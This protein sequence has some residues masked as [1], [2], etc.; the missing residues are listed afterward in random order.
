MNADLPSEG[1][2]PD[3]APDVG[4]TEAGAERP[5]LSIAALVEQWHGV[6]LRASTML[7]EPEAT[8][9]IAAAERA[10]EEIA[11]LIRDEP[12]AS[13]LLHIHTA[14]A[15]LQRYSVTHALLVTVV[16]DLASRALQGCTDE[17]RRSL[18][19]AALTMNIGMTRLQDELALQIGKVTPE[20]RSLIDG[21]AAR[22]A[23]LLTEMGVAD[24]LWLE[25]VTH[26]H[27]TPPG[28]LAEQPIAMQLARLVQRAD[29]FAA[30]MSPRKARAALS[31]ALAAKGAYYDENE[32]PDEAGS[33]VIKA[34]GIYP[35]GSYVQLAS[36]ELAIVLR[37]GSAPNK[38]VVA[39]IADSNGIPNVQPVLR[40]TDK[41][42]NA[43][44]R[45]VAPTDVRVRTPVERLLKLAR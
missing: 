19:R 13:L 18:R 9:F 38:P 5:R 10:D 1:D 44:V 28:P 34:V 11:A 3:A 42:A 17:H 26:H 32:K 4:S 23:E 8:S 37:R 24:E 6:T 39:G 15:D 31:A 33:L 20:Q 14:G 22:S 16:C 45:G 30:R 25:A 35:A 41:S 43:I 40:T 27:N 36:G 12:E 2:L 29:V 21:H 7:R